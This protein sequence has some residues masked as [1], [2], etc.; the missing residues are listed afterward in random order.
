[1][2]QQPLQSWLT[3]TKKLQSL[4]NKAHYLNQL[5]QLVQNYLNEDIAPH[6]Q[7]ANYEAGKLKLIVDSSAWASRL[8]FN[9]PHLKKTLSA[10]QP[11]THLK[12]IEYSVQPQYESIRELTPNHIP[13]SPANQALLASAAEAIADD[14]LKQA[15]LNLANRRSRSSDKP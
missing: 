15:L 10:I 5:T 3:D 11:F 8:R 14:K 7:V 4:I 1:M 6:C 12:T 13:I 2:P 9:L